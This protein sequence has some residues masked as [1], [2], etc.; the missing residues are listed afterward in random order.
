MTADST[1]WRVFES[2]ANKAGISLSALLRFMIEGFL[3]D[4]DLVRGPKDLT[5][6]WVR[7]EG[8]HAKR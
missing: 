6:R 8:G 5:P 4:F 1:Y 2:K 3:C 7:R